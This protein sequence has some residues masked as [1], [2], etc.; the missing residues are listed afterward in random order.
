M[1]RK[2]S[3]RPRK[4]GT[5][6]R[7]HNTYDRI[8]D[9]A[10]RIL[11]RDGYTLTTTNHI[12]ADASISIGSL[13]QYFPN[14]EAVF[15][16]LAQRHIERMANSWH[17]NQ[18][19]LATAQSVTE[20]VAKVVEFATALSN[21]RLHQVLFREAIRTDVLQQKLMAFDDQICTTLVRELRRIG[22]DGRNLELRVRLAVAAADEALH[23][24]VLV[25]PSPAE[26]HLA[27]GI[28]TAMIAASL[29]AS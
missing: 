24:V 5:Q 1:P 19:Q 16:A 14:R 6:Q 18:D 23:R 27:A 10:A 15:A 28:L 20:L 11:S 22:S 12:A 7:A 29:E 21:D 8:L 3:L 2:P 17:A 25:Q 9:S 4:T 26:R 13:Y